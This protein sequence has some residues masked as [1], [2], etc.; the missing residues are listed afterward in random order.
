MKRYT[1]IEENGA[2]AIKNSTYLYIH[3]KRPEEI[4]EINPVYLDIPLILCRLQKTHKKAHITFT[5]R[6][7]ASTDCLV[8]NDPECTNCVKLDIL[9]RSERTDGCWSSLGVSIPY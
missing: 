1:L 2:L 4:L 6:Q 8:V 7:A 9:A 5:P 3:C